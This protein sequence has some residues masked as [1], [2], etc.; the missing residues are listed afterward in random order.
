M[1]KNHIDLP[2][3]LPYSRCSIAAWPSGTLCTY[4][5][6]ETGQAHGICTYIP[7]QNDHDLSIRVFSEFPMGERGV[8][9]VPDIFPSSRLIA[10]GE[11]S[12]GMPDMYLALLAFA[13][14]A[15]S[16][17]RSSKRRNSGHTVT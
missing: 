10:G 8:V 14:I 3:V 6:H 5:D 15:P 4:S 12:V 7:D 2:I 13:S 11:V 1:N 16:Q 17:Q 9:F